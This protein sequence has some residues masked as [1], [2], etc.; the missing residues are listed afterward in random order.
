MSTGHLQRSNGIRVGDKGRVSFFVL[1]RPGALRV[2]IEELED[3]CVVVSFQ[4]IV[5]E[6]DQ[7]GEEF[8]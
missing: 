1:P 3:S 2:F 6:S 7:L 5:L 4:V 8:P